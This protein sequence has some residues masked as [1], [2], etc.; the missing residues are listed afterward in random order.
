MR[1]RANTGA[2]LSA[3]V[4]VAALALMLTATT[5]SAQGTVRKTDDVLGSVA[6]LARNLELADVPSPIDISADRLEFDYDEGLLRYQGNVTVAHA[7]ITIRSSSLD[8]SF[9]PDGKRRLKRITARGSVEVLRGKETASGELAEYDPTAATIVLSQ[10]ARLG[11]GPNSL[12]GE[13]VVVYLD[14]GRAVVQGRDP[15]APAPESTGE[16]TPD[17]KAAPG[18]VRV[19]LMPDSLDGKKPDAAP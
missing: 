17:G 10:Q 4:P 13:R 1:V 12:A 18:R 2:V 7:G 6:G 11:S 19:I 16:P 8:V 15:G 5:A 9:E 3:A 14:E